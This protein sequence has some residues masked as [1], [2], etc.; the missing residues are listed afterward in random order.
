MEHAVY[1][2]A[3]L[4][5]GLGAR[6]VGPALVDEL[7]LELALLHDWV[8]LG[9]VLGAVSAK[10]GFVDEP[11]LA[12]AF[13]D[14][15]MHFRIDDAICACILTHQF[16]RNAYPGGDRPH[17][18][19]NPV[20]HP[21]AI[22]A[23]QR[24]GGAWPEMLGNIIGVELQSG[25]LVRARDHP[26]QSLIGQS[27]LPV[28]ATDIRMGAGKPDLLHVLPVLAWLVDPRGRREGA[29]P[30]VDGHGMQAVLDMPPDL[31]V[32]ETAGPCG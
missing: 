9:Q 16:L 17:V 25:E 26:D 18:G 21:A 12:D 23:E 7:L 4:L 5:G 14:A 29:A 6:P 19:P 31:V 11:E 15:P 28:A 20:K 30:L 8:I 27:G 32:A 24:A 10:F 13:P 22:R 2:P 3:A 1:R